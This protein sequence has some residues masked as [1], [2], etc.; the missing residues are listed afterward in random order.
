MR[1]E[2]R[3]VRPVLL[4]AFVIKLFAS[5]ATDIPSPS[6]QHAHADSPLLSLLSAATH[7]RA[8]SSSTTCCNALAGRPRSSLPWSS[9]CRPP[10]SSTLKDDRVEVIP[11]PR[12]VFGSLA[13]VWRDLTEE[14]WV[15]PTEQF[16]EANLRL[17]LRCLERRTLFL[18]DHAH[19]DVVIRV[20][21]RPERYE[22]SAWAR[23]INLLTDLAWRAVS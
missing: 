23:T 14:E 20:E 8:S 5:D 19:V 17:A 21:C 1:T 15:E 12:H 2:L 7:G 3:E 18:H 13:A 16:A 6:G 10:S 11:R 9:T 22:D 4:C